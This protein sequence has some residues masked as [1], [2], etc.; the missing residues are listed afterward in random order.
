M[1]PPRR[2]NPANADVTPRK[3]LSRSGRLVQ[4][5]AKS[6]KPHTPLVLCPRILNNPLHGAP[7][8]SRHLAV[9]NRRNR[10]ALDFGAR[11]Q[12][13]LKRITTLS[14]DLAA[15]G[16]QRRPPAHSLR[17]LI[18][19]D[20]EAFIQ[21]QPLKITF[22]SHCPT[23]PTRISWLWNGTENFVLLFLLEI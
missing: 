1:T 18:P 16:R 14:A 19:L 23:P 11:A 15:R 7:L 5:L 10:V 2:K 13:F 6:E 20:P 9:L 17:L 22:S 4:V 21:Q 12:D 3:S 8:P